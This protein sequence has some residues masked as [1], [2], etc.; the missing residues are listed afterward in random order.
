MAGKW[1]IVDAHNQFIPE[2][3]I[4]KS[5]GMST[6]LTVAGP[7]VVPYR[8]SVNLEAKLKVM[9]EAGIDMAVIHMASLNYLGL[10]FC[11]AMNDGNARLMREY[12]DRL[13]GLAHLPL[14][15]AG[16]AEC[17]K[18]VDR[19]ISGLGLKGIA[20]ETNTAKTVLGSASLFPLYE[21]ISQL[22][23][24]IVIH[25]AFGARPMIMEK[26]PSAESLKAL[27]Y[28]AIDVEIDNTRA[29]V[30]A[31]FGVLNYFPEI[32]FLMPHH[33]GA[34]PFWQGRMM[35]SFLP[36]GFELPERLRG[37]GLPA[38]VPRI[39]AELGLD[40]IWKDLFDKL[41]FDT[42]GFQGWMPITEGTLMSV[43][44][45]RLAFGTD[46]GFEMMEAVDIKGFI[47]DIKK[48]K[49]PEEDRRN[50]LGETARTMFKLKK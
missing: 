35:N 32:K 18:E 21:K 48:L 42:S 28:Q 4:K 26:K 29:C 40:K 8:A 10:E 13:I 9:D 37:T 22:D 17:L 14:D 19:A 31:M 3:A 33:G 38:R 25:P 1:F 30:E 39:R 43:R 2:E 46:Y 7:A 23:V 27:M 41:Y 36:V 49:L 47:D 16:T 50:I 5:R 24:P 11:Q 15:T 34:L 6:D 45:D 44:A 12:P 20:L